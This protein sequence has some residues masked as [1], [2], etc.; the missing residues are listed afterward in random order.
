MIMSDMMHPKQ[1]PYFTLSWMHYKIGGVCKGVFFV[2]AYY[3]FFAFGVGELR[4]T[5]AVADGL[6]AS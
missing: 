2:F 3:M 1:S 4:A 6:A 5:I